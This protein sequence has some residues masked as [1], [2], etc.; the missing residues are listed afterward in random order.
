MATDISW[1][2]SET[3]DAKI[4]RLEAEVTRLKSIVAASGAALDVRLA[5]VIHLAR[6]QWQGAFTYTPEQIIERIERDD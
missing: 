5:E 3:P 2:F 4:A 6:Q 1:V